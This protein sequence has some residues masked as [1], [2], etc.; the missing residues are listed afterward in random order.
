[1]VIY[2]FTT[3][4]F[5][6]PSLVMFHNSSAQSPLPSKTVHQTKDSKI[7]PRHL[8]VERRK[9]V[10][11]FFEL[12]SIDDGL[13]E[14]AFK[15]QS[16]SLFSPSFYC[17]TSL[18]LLSHNMDDTMRDTLDSQLL[19]WLNSPA[20]D[21]RRLEDFMDEANLKHFIHL[22]DKYATETFRV[23]PYRICSSLC[24]SWFDVG[25]MEELESQK[26]KLEL[27]GLLDIESSKKSIAI[28]PL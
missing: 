18:R 2:H 22:S 10:E 3:L 26:T 23:S 14:I 25:L 4:F 19:A 12:A 9:M 17:V 27:R 16:Q 6:A 13:I 20:F 21:H 5:I 7:D 1:M 8:A 24:A 11:F 28:R 15:P